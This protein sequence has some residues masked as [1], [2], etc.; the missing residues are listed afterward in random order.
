MAS[1][2]LGAVVDAFLRDHSLY[3]P[4]PTSLR[5]RSIPS[6]SK[7]SIPSPSKRSRGPDEAVDDILPSPR[8]PKRPRRAPADGAD[9]SSL[10]FEA[11][12]QNIDPE[13][14]SFSHPSMQRTACADLNDRIRASLDGATLAREGS[15][16]SIRNLATRPQ[17]R[18]IY[19]YV[20]QRSSLATS[21]MSTDSLDAPSAPWRNRLALGQKRPHLGC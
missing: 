20:R 11:L 18:V 1:D 17:L 2:F 14:V 3:I 10:P 15:S 12:T 4:P 19:A 16:S 9:G 21:H 7:R 13:S 6:P 5:E 8:P